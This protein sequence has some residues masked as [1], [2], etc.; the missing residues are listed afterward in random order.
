MG[1]AIVGTLS[2]AIGGFVAAYLAKK[3]TLLNSGLVGALLVIIGALT[4]NDLPSWIN[5]LEDVLAIPAA[6]LGG[7]FAKSRLASMQLKRE[8]LAIRVQ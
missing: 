2:I 6:L 3:G 7:Y 1:G 8:K 5:I 4:S